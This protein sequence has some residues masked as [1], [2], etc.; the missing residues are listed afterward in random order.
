MELQKMLGYEAGNLN[1]N[2]DGHQKLPKK[3][4]SVVSLYDMS[5]K[6]GP[7]QGLKLTGPMSRSETREHDQHEL[8]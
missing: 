4:A 8:W 2:L 6:Q 3:S 5:Q 1:E 7:Q